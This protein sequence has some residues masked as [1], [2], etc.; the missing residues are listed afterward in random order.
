MLFNFIVLMVVKGC[1]VL[2]SCVNFHFGVDLHV[3]DWNVSKGGFNILFVLGYSYF[4]L[5]G[6]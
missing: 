3:G 6:L 2:T 5:F 4:Y 1:K